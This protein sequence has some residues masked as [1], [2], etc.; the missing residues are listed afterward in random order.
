MPDNANK[1][2]Q[3]LI[4]RVKPYKTG[5]RVKPIAYEILPADL[6]D[7]VIRAKELKEKKRE[8]LRK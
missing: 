7:L 4:E 1:I 8:R 2:V 5:S 3:D 6:L